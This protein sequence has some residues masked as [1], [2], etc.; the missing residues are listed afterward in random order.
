MESHDCLLSLQDSNSV[1]LLVGEGFQKMLEDANVWTFP[2]K[3]TFWLSRSFKK[4]NQV[5]RPLEYF[6]IARP[7]LT[8][9]P[10]PFTLIPLQLLMSAD[11]L[12]RKRTELLKTTSLEKEGLYAAT[13]CKASNNSSVDYTCDPVQ[14]HLCTQR[15]MFLWVYMAAPS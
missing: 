15:A 9:S 5:L 8:F 7:S 12:L 4:P 13:H 14:H 3:K 1:N 11:P 10:M 6:S 2:L